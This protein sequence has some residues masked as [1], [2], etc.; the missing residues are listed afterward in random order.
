MDFSYTPEQIQLRKEVR[1][2]AEAEIGPHVMEWDEAQTFPQEVVRKL[3]EL[4]YMGSISPR[5]WGAPVSAISSIR[6]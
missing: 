6:S 3:G 1:E 5:I 2:F 4:G